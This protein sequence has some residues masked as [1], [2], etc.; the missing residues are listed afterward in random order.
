MY[1]GVGGKRRE[2]GAGQEGLIPLLCSSLATQTIVFGPAASRH[3][4]GTCPK[5]GISGSSP[6][7]LIQNLHFLTRYLGILTH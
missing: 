3:H 6:D 1:L 7:L 4:L 2:N 5:Y